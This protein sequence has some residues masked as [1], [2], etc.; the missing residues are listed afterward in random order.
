MK[1][2]VRLDLPFDSELDAESL[3]DFAKKLI[4]KAVSIN[5]GDDSEEIAYCDYHKC[6]HDEIPIKPCEPIERVEV[7]TLVSPPIE[8]GF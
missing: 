4:G 2:R 1:Y 8:L 5:E 6:Y 3:V 7:K